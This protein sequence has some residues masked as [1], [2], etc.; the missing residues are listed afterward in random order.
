MTNR[1]LF[2]AAAVF[3][4][5]AGPTWAQDDFTGLMQ[6]GKEAMRQMKVQDAEVDFRRALA[7]DPL[8]VDALDALG[9][10]VYASGARVPS[11]DAKVP[12]SGSSRFD[13]A[14]ELLEKAIG[15]DPNSFAA[16]YD[17]AR[18][19]ASQCVPA[20]V[21]A[22]LEAGALKP[23]GGSLP[24]GPA[25]QNLRLQIGALVESGVEHAQRAV[26][27]E[28]NSAPAMHQLAGLLRIRAELDETSET[29]EADRSLAQD[30]SRRAA[31]PSELAPQGVPRF[32]RIGA[33]VAEANLIGRVDPVY[34]P[35]ARAARVQ[36]AV[37]FTI[38]IDET[39]RVID[40]KLASGHPLLV[41]A[42]KEAV[43]QWMYRP[44]LLNG[45]PVKV[46]TTA[47]VVFRLPE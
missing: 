12:F 6:Q 10:A 16:H 4:L 28:P 8:S 21:H 15:V 46:S 3:L 18:I 37:E 36:G 19:I 23:T 22:S 1:L 27:I 32:V 31:T 20:V 24:F 40:A 7:L 41:Q 2:G 5:A 39:G 9:D 29:S 14:K 11:Q 35:L 26:A 47:D 25:R 34:P 44:T 30:W 43:M 13:E 38:T 45:Q 42:A 33:R 17:L